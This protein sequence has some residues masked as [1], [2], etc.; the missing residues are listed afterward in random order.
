M[1]HGP[2]PRAQVGGRY[3]SGH[4]ERRALSVRE[5]W[6]ALQRLNRRLQRDNA[7]EVGA[8][9]FTWRFRSRSLLEGLVRQQGR[10]LHPGFAFRS[11]L[12]DHKKVSYNFFTTIVTRSATR[13]SG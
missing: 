1:M 11:L 5:R 3:A 2:R 8:N 10:R 4:P 13:R 9:L 7:A 6:E 12:A